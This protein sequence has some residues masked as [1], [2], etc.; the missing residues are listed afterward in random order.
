MKT[1]CILVPEGAAVVNCIEGSYV[2]FTRLNNFLT[3]EGKQPLFNVMLTGISME[4]RIYDGFFS[5]KPHSDICRTAH[6][7]IGIQ[8][9]CY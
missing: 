8:I 3:S 5:V 6:G 4:P 7:N 9:F 2:L 1:I